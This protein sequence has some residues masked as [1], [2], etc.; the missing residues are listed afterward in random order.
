MESRFFKCG[1]LVAIVAVVAMGLVVAA[2]AVCAQSTYPTKFIRLVNPYPAGG[3]LDVLAREMMKPMSEQLGQQFVLDNRPGAGATLGADIVAKAAPDGYT[4][5]LSG[6]PSHVIVPAMMRVPY[7]GIRDFAPIAMFATIANLM[8]AKAGLPVTN[9]QSV[10][11]HA[12]ANPGK[13]T[14]GSPGNGS[15]G[16]LATELLKKLAAINLV[17]VPYKGGGPAAV[18]VMGGHIDLA[19]VNITAVLPHIQAGRVRAVVMGTRK[20]SELLPDLPTVEESGFRG[21]DAGTWYGVFAPTKTPRAIVNTLHTNL[22]KAMA[23]PGIKGRLQQQG[24]DI[25]LMTP[26]AL[27]KHLAR[28]YDEL[29]PLIKS[30]GLTA[31]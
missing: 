16:H 17:H 11:D 22:V 27:T 1:R 8:V 23:T 29:V 25:T 18:D 5:L 21:Y 14:Y 20:R 19:F 2:S 15:I 13:I 9:L 10:I 28:E 24:A 3:P 4:L 26:D 6:S 7:D 31:N 12:K 30:I